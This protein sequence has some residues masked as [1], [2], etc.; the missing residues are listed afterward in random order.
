MIYYSRYAYPHC[1]LP[2]VPRGALALNVSLVPL[3]PGEGTLT[4]GAFT[5][6]LALVAGCLQRQRVWAW[7]EPHQAQRLGSCRGR[8]EHRRRYGHRHCYGHERCYGHRGGVSKP[9]IIASLS[10]LSKNG[11]NPLV[12]RWG[13]NFFYR[14]PG[15]K[16][17]GGKPR[18][19]SRRRTLTPLF[20]IIIIHLFLQGGLW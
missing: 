4:R 10:L 20:I 19:E 13:F 6:H 14:D 2:W 1:H 15:T 11:A 7:Q 17:A 5:L 18:L 16:N 12:L 3:F 9:H 8:Y